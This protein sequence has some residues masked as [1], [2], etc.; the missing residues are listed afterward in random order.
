MDL[1]KF[2]SAFYKAYK[3]GFLEKI[4]TAISEI[5][6]KYLITGAKSM[7]FIMAIRFLTDFLNG[8]IYYKT[9][10]GEHNLDRSKNQFK[11]LE[12]LNNQISEL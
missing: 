10:Y 12:S 5:E 6:S 1:V 7:I 8:D 4:G 11:L 9:S 2:N 3:K